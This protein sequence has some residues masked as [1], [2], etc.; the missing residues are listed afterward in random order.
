ML[1][2]YLRILAI[3]NCVGMFLVL[4]MGTLVTKTHSGLA[5]GRQWP[6]CNGKFV[7]AYTIS[8]FIEYGHRLVSGLVGILVLV[9][10]VLT[11]LYSKRKDARIY[12]VGGFVTTVLQ[13]ALGAMAVVWPQTPLVMALHFGISLMAFAFTL[14]LL[15]VLWNFDPNLSK[16]EEL[17]R[18]R[19]RVAV[20]ASQSGMISRLHAQTWLV[21][22]YC[23]GVVYLGAY[24]RHTQSSGGCGKEFP[25]CAGKVVPDHLTGA[26]GIMFIHRAAAFLL[27]VLIVWLA[28]EARRGSYPKEVRTF[29]NWSLYLVI[30]QIFSGIFVTLVLDMEVMYL[31]AALIHAVLIA[32]LFGTL[33]YLSI[34]LLHI[35]HIQGGSVRG[36]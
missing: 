30:L 13:A 19:A 7:P 32:G 2:K 15:A 24:V 3:W 11:Y 35:R 10:L 16:E 31:F 4:V 27:F 20:V 6:L 14:M 5:C 29:A 25:L 9:V 18:Y 12:A 21:T 1:K 17:E 23:Y 28:Y 8:S 36:S 26:T 33:T 34:L 22:I